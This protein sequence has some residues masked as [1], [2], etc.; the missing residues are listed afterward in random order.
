MKSRILMLA[1]GTVA[2]AAAMTG[3]N[4]IDTP[5]STA[6]AG[7]APKTDFKPNVDAGVPVTITQDPN[8]IK[9][10][11][12]IKGFSYR[13]EPFALL[14]VEASF[15]RSQASERFV[16][17][18]NWSV[19]FEPPVERDPSLDDQEEPQPYRRLAGII[20][21]DTVM[22]ILIMED[23][24]AEIIRP[25]MMIPNTEWRVISI[26]EEKAVLRRAGNRRPRTI[27]I[28]LEGD[29]RG[30][31]GAA[32][33]GGA[34]PGGGTGGGPVGGDGGERGGRGGRGDL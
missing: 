10:L 34:N 13:S 11:V 18:N 20:V 32:P 25:G 29:L 27:T 31:G 1:F 12:A 4:N 30:A 33:R 21:G 15:E 3:C 16:Q 8:L 6:S 28:P 9:S 22:A 26:D 17:Q 19:Q 14:P 2:V 23:G 5:A 24:H 7:A